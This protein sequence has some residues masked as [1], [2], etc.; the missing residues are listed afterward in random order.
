MG[1]HLIV[2]KPSASLL[3]HARRNKEHAVVDVI[4]D[5]ESAEAIEAGDSA[6]LERWLVAEGDQ[7]HAGDLL[8]Q[9]RLVQ[10]AVDVRASHAGV[11]EQIL[12]NAG[13]R[14]APGH[15]LARLIT[16]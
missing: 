12:V 9:A 16:L 4:L 7:V 14:F 13:E 6:L 8:A 11:L 15:A 1:R 2:R 5:P 3:F 10:Q